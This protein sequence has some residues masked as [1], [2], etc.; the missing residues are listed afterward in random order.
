[1]D[2][3]A[4]VPREGPTMAQGKKRL[5]KKHRQASTRPKK[6]RSPRATPTTG[7][8]DPRKRKILSTK[9]AAADKASRVTKQSPEHEKRKAIRPGAAP[10]KSAATVRPKFVRPADGIVG[11]QTPR[12]ENVAGRE[13]IDEE[14]WRDVELLASQMV[15][16][17]ERAEARELPLIAVC[18]RPNVGKSTL[19][20]RLTGSRRW[21]VGAGTGRTRGRRYR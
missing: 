2:N 8:V 18:G 10:K 3:G 15:T 12:S 16:E 21:I 7:A 14:D 1:M 9:R 11:R 17:T 13:R 20:N 6:G 19:F 4:A 5:G